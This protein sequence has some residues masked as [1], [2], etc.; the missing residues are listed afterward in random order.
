LYTV[1][2]SSKRGVF[3]ALGNY[4]EVANNTPSLTYDPVTLAPSGLLIESS[5]TNYIRNP[6][7]EGASAS[8]G[9]SVPTYWSSSV[10]S[11]G[12]S[13]IV[14][15]T[16]VES[17]LSYFDVRITGTGLLNQRIILRPDAFRSVAAAYGETWTASAFIRGVAGNYGA[18]V[19]NIRI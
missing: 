3:D 17:G 7:C 15:G 13:M 11:T 6:R 16:G 19:M 5:K 1:A 2:R 9:G 10:Y 4:A 18:D 12:L 14:V 8:S